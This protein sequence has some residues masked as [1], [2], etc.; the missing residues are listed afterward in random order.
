MQVF[1]NG[2][3]TTRPE[4]RGTFGCA[5]ATHWLAAATAMRMLENG[6]NAFDAAVAAGFALQVLEPHLNGPAGE[7][8]IMLWNA[9]QKRADVICG[10]GVAPQGATID[11]FR[12]LGLDMVPGTGPL[13]ACVPGAFGAW[14]MLLRDHGTMRLEE[15]LRPAIEFAGGGFSLNARVAQTMASME[16]LFR[17][18]WTSSAEIYLPHGAPP[19]AGHL[20]RNRTLAATFERILRESEGGGREVQIERAHHLWYEGFVAEAI[21]R[22]AAVPVLDSTGRHHTGFLTAADMAAWKPTYEAPVSRHYAGVEVFKCG[23]WTQGPA[24]LEWLGLLEGTGVGDLDPLGADFIHLVVETGKLALADRDAWLGDDTSP[25]DALL[26]DSYLESRR[27]CVGDTSSAELRPGSPLGREPKLPPRHL[28]GA[29]F[30]SA[31]GV[32]EPTFA[33]DPE[34]RKK[35]AMDFAG[36]DPYGRGDTCHIAVTDRFGNMVAATPSGGWFQ[37]SPVVPELGFGLGTRAQMFWLVDGLPSSLAPGK[38]PR[39][40]LTPTMVAKDGAPSLAFGTPGGDQ[41]EQW[42]IAFLLRHLH[43]GFNLQQAIDAPAFHTGHLISSF[44]PREFKP[45]SV[46][47]EKR[48]GQDVGKALE[49]R[50]HRIEWAAEWSLG[51]LCAVGRETAGNDV[52]LK[53]AANARGMQDYAVGR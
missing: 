34:G 4:I 42:S 43:H 30:S 40:T 11:A 16:D 13:A 8:P 6:G 14:L 15:V 37:A 41:Q 3:F 21:E 45:S 23:A 32:G 51:R 17:S 25:V 26:S 12:S 24:F 20:F 36:F 28:L 39:T 5:A 9:Q 44:W 2:A 52:I 31:P 1:S 53:S 33:K 46:I 49:A 50:G 48:F 29:S 18:E 22:A 7:V 47:L 38:R 19:L 35:A 10:Q 27:H